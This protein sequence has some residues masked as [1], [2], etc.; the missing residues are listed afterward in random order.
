MDRGKSVI[1]RC[2]LFLSPSKNKDN[3]YNKDMM[4]MRVVENTDSFKAKIGVDDDASIGNSLFVGGLI[5]TIAGLVASK[6]FEFSGLPFL[7]AI[8]IGAPT[9]S[10]FAVVTTAFF[11]LVGGAAVTY[12]VEKFK[13][14][15]KDLDRKIV[16]KSFS[17]SIHEVG[18]Y[19]AKLVFYPQIMLYLQSSV[20]PEMI[21]KKLEG[22]FTSWGYAP[23]FGKQFVFDVYQQNSK[24]A[25]KFENEIIKLYELSLN[26]KKYAWISKLVE[27]NLRKQSSS[28]QKV[29]KSEIL[30]ETFVQNIKESFIEA[31]YELPETTKRNEDFYK[32]II[33][34]IDK[35][36]EK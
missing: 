9:F 16:R 29:K 24:N 2:S 7:V 17:G 27:K 10:V 32:K 14:Q 35:R 6:V 5:A 33:A 13:K 19:C 11:A 31:Y 25:D 30:T 28:N 12:Y 36:L 34:I 21:W 22:E 26:K 15:Y 1:W 18:K 4:K 3:I 8:I 20:S 23:D